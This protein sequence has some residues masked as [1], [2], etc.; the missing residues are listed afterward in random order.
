MSSD[1][2]LSLVRR[3]HIDTDPGID[4]LLALALALAS[5]ELRVEGLT[6][7]AGNVSL[8]QATD[9]TRRFLR[10]VGVELPV[11]RGAA[12]P[13]A[14]DAVDARQVHGPDGRHGLEL[15]PAPA[16]PLPTAKALLRSSLRERRIDEIVALG[17][18]TNL[19]ALALEEPGL[20]AETEV[21]WMGGSLGE[22]NATPL[23]EFNAYA[24]P[25]ALSVILESATHLRII[26]LDVTRHV[27][28]R[29][30]DVPNDPFGETPLG[31]S[32]E[33]LLSALMEIERPL[34]GEALAVLHDPCAVVAA[35][36]P[37]LFRYEDRALEVCAEEGRERGRLL[38]RDEGSVAQFAVEAHADEITRLFLRRLAGLAGKDES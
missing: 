5:P 15:P 8:D 2:G 32:L 7:V 6:T 20:L 12:G 38:E 11:G 3:I 26:P 18:L 33:A 29:P 1:A 22:G 16:E 35:I 19:A 9:N 36:S 25:T 30:R 23:A 21:V 10:L 34:Q 27:V 28:L 17:P 14:L 31:R 4:D 24:D 13:L 37:N